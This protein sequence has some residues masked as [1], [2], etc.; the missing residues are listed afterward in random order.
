MSDRQ[1][2]VSVYD[3]GLS[4]ADG[5]ENSIL[6]KYKGKVTLIFN[7]AAGCG[8]IPQHIAL[9]RL[10]QIYKDEPDF[11][12]LA[13]TVDDFCCHGYEEFQDGLNSY[14]EKNNVNLLPGQVAQS[15]AQENFG[16][17]Y[18]FSELTNGRYDKH[19]YDRN[20]VPGSV[21]EQDIHLLW[22][23]LTEAHK[24]DL[25]ENG[26]PYHDERI[27][28]SD[29]YRVSPPD[30]KTGF[31]PLTGNFEKFLVSRSGRVIRRYPNAF[32]LGER[33]ENNIV[34]PWFNDT[35]SPSGVPEYKPNHEKRDEGPE[36]NGPYPTP[37]QER[38]ISMS[39]ERICRD[40][41]QFISQQVE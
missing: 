33:D 16:A 34:Y 39:L 31:T 5:S 9:E 7:V 18:S 17:T 28:W 21:K 38:G 11:N 32:L 13:V 3:I 20:F 35:D 26:L 2:P 27:P 36:N 15:Y 8:N 1:L 29:T 19:R 25:A 40:I 14:I 6:A 10:N 22:Y 30:G 23:Y 12:I 24:A 37:Y 41:D 4:S